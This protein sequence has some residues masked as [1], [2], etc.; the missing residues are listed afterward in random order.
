MGQ[1]GWKVV[2]QGVC[3]SGGIFGQTTN[4]C[5]HISCFWICINIC[6]LHYLVSQIKKTNMRIH[7]SL[8]L[9]I[10]FANY[11]IWYCKFKNTTMF[12]CLH[13]IPNVV[14]CKWYWKCIQCCGHTCLLCVNLPYHNVGF[15]MCW[16]AMNHVFLWIWN[17]HVVAQNLYCKFKQWPTVCSES[18][19]LWTAMNMHCFEFAIPVLL[20]NWFC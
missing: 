13:F 7:S 20:H 1:S 5:V 6:K 3:N 19:R 8:E 17:T 9:A 16:N 4:L 10:A 11:Q 15:I 18:S 2:G 12:V 14:C